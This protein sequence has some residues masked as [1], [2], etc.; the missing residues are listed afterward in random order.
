L[1]P[2]KSQQLFYEDDIEYINLDESLSQNI[3]D[4]SE[5]KS[6]NKKYN[7]TSIAAFMQ[8]TTNYSNDG[9]KKKLLHKKN[10]NCVSNRNLNN[11]NDNNNYF[12]N[13]INNNDNTSFD[14]FTN[15]YLDF[16]FV[17]EW[18]KNVNKLFN[19]TLINCLMK[20]IYSISIKK[21]F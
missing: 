9:F 8:R 3:I 17:L 1:E 10:T 7:D 5:S 13:N 15:Q 16:D 6:I 4:D 19:T 12:N 20:L 2:T 21:L 14:S 11:N 18:D